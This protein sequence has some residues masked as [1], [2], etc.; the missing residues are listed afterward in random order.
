MINING[1]TFIYDIFIKQ[2]IL[3]LVST[4][5]S[6][7]DPPISVYV[8]GAKTTEVGYNQCEPARYFYIT[9]PENPNITIK[10]NDKEYY[11][12]ARIEQS[13]STD[14]I[15]IG[16]LFKD[17]Y[18]RITDFIKYYT[19]QGIS[20][21]YLYYNGPTLP[22]NLPSGSNI[23]YRC[24]NYPYWHSDCQHRHGAQMPFLTTMRLLHIPDHKWFFLIDLD[25]FIIHTDHIKLDN[26][27]DT[28]PHSIRVIQ[29][30]NHWA[31]KEGYM[32]TYSKNAAPWNM[33]S[34][35]IYRNTFTDLCSIHA[36]KNNANQLQDT[37]LEMLHAVDDH[38]VGSCPKEDRLAAIID[39]IKIV[40]IRDDGHIT[41]N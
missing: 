25:E 4:Y 38:E 31:K 2:N 19:S 3:Y 32:I 37:N 11:F 1:K 26:Y 7:S 8:N 27:L 21:F 28:I 34:K 15:G 14:K 10:I 24:W 41:S 30:R 13:I 39:P 35:C 16:T 9:A 33:R 22:A 6:H 20:E 17:D 18:N 36:P 12:T 23:H 40:I 29:V 5:Y